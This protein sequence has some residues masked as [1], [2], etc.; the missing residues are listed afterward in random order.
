[1]KVT[2]NEPMRRDMS[3]YV[4]NML[5]LKAKSRISRSTSS[6]MFHCPFHKDKTPSFSM[7][8][9][10][11]VW[12]CFS[13]NRSGNIES[14]YKEFT[15]GNLH[16]EMGINSLSAYVYNNRIVPKEVV[17]SNTKLKSVFVNFDETDIK[18]LSSE[19]KA[20][21]YVK[22]RG[23]TLEVAKSMHMGYVDDSLIN[24]TRF[25]HRVVIP[26]YEDGR[27]ISIEGRRINPEDPNPKV[28]YPK[29][30]SVNTLFDLDK[31]DRNETLYAVEGLMDLAV[32]RTC[33]LF[34]NSTSIF[35]ASLTR[36]QVE[37]LKEFKRVVYIND[38]D[39]AGNKTLETLRS[40]ESD[41]FFSLKLPS[42]I[43]GV[44]IKDVGDLPKA[45]VTPTD[46][47]NRRWLQHIKRL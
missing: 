5:G 27:L 38:L 16:K 3:L 18:P 19:P 7:D 8:L 29:N 12:H 13:C 15:G 32:L 37:L 33:S 2:L 14:L 1:M 44:K 43:R 6:M 26:I 9:D 31:L 46:L 22:G 35:G 36:R 20:E 25:L 23:I 17:E 30:A 41:K 47:V 40:L 11:G 4:I 28:L 24:N 39:D 42:E 10:N 21:E 45:G 34:K